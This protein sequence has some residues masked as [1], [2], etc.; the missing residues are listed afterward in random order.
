MVIDEP[1]RSS[2]EAANGCS[3]IAAV[4][5]SD[6]I[7][8]WGDSMPTSLARPRL[9]N[10]RRPAGK[11]H[12]ALIAAGRIAQGGIGVCAPIPTGSISIVQLSMPTAVW[13]LPS[14]RALDEIGSLPEIGTHM[15]RSRRG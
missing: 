10:V 8:Y 5:T 15:E 4:T 12:Q 14:L 6:S 2:T 11:E 9:T 3:R 7:V 1:W 13:L